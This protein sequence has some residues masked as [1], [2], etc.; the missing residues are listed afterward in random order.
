MAQE[1]LQERWPKFTQ[2]LLPALF[3]Q[4][5]PGLNASTQTQAPS[6]IRSRC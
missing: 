2:S 1:A 4:L 3:C 6:L 5:V